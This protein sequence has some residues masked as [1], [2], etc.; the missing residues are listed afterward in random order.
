MS[1]YQKV[2]K[3]F[4]AKVSMCCSEKNTDS[5]Y[6]LLLFSQLFSAFSLCWDLKKNPKPTFPSNRKQTKNMYL[7]SPWLDIH[8]KPLRVEVQCTLLYFFRSLQLSQYSLKPGYS[9]CLEF[10]RVV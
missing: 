6:T 3:I 9:F 10:S 7:I 2:R 1:L 8:K 4:V 5:Y